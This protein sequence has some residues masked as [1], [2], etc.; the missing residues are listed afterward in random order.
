MSHQRRMLR[1]VQTADPQRCPSLYGAPEGCALR[2]DTELMLL[3]PACLPGST[4]LASELPQVRGTLRDAPVGAEAG[5]ATEY[6][7]STKIRP[8]TASSWRP[9]SRCE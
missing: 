9:G 4:T 1:G 6:Y 7:P 3:S 2:P 8:S 5:C